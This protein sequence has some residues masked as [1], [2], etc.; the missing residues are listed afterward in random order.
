[1]APNNSKAQ[2][3]WA[4]VA[5][6]VYLLLIALFMGADQAARAIAGS[7]GFAEIAARLA[8]VL[9]LYRTV[10]AVNVVGAALTIVLAV[11]LY[12]TVKPASPALARLALLFRMAEGSLEAVTCTAAF[13]IVRLYAAPLAGF[14]L[15]QM[16]GLVSL[17]RALQGGMFNIVTTL[18]GIGSILFFWIL[19]VSRSIPRLLSVFGFLASLLVPVIGLAGS[20]L[21]ESAKEFAPAWYPIL[22]AEL[23][24]G[25][26]LLFFAVKTASSAKE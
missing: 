6:L 20:I 24:T 5:G 13:A 1:M 16:Q 7:G 23:T 14:D 15:Q 17:L 12:E 9:P 11:A 10:L 2:R 4:R 18:F 8:P 25:A 21:P 3:A 26:W 19:I 22:I